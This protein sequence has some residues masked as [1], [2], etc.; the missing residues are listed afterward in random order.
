MQKIDIRGPEVFPGD[1]RGEG[2]THPERNIFAHVEGVVAD[3]DVTG[4]EIVFLAR[5]VHDMCEF[6]SV[7]HGDKF[8]IA[9][10][11]DGREIFPGE[12]MGFVDR[13]HYFLGKEEGFF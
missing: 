8:F 7:G 2:D 9:E 1:G 13:Q 10:V 11:V 4:L 6:G 5:S 12:G 3:D